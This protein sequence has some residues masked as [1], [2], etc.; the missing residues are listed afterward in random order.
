M[1][2]MITYVTPIKAMYPIV[3]APNPTGSKIGYGYHPVVIPRAIDPNRYTNGYSA[4]KG[5]IL[6]LGRISFF[7]S[8]YVMK[9]HINVTGN[10][11]CIRVVSIP[12]KK[13]AASELGFAVP[14]AAQSYQ[15][16]AGFR[17]SK[18]MSFAFPHCPDMIN[19][20]I[21]NDATMNVNE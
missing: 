18:I 20:V 21:K 11:T 5:T 19:G 9:S 8:L 14:K 4:H 2:A 1:N 7:S 6:C 10:I 3:D 16:S 15:G 17:L 12:Q 13:L